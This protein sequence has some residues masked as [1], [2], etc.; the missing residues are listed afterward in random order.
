MRLKCYAC[1][2]IELDSFIPTQ[3]NEFL[4]IIA[5]LSNGG[6]FFAE[7][8]PIGRGVE[9][10]RRNKSSPVPVPIHVHSPVPI[11]FISGHTSVSSSLE[12]FFFLFARGT[13][14]VATRIIF[15]RQRYTRV[16]TLWRLLALWEQLEQSRILREQRGY[17]GRGALGGFGSRASQGVNY[18]RKQYYRTNYRT[19]ER[20]SVKCRA[21]ATGPL[22]TSLFHVNVLHD[23]NYLGGWPIGRIQK[24]T[25]VCFFKFYTV[26][27][28]VALKPFILNRGRCFDRDFRTFDI[29]SR[30]YAYH[31]MFSIIYYIW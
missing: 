20:N 27:P 24:G 10:L 18:A 16:T 11:Y 4:R 23:I 28:C 22:I 5:W 14:T 29:F 31:Y 30:F 2:F 19:G 3:S 6:G 17:G 7:S 25:S 1:L 12:S 9:V 21:D 13:A 26:P 15:V 8:T